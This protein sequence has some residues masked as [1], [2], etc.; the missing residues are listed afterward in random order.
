MT[1]AGRDSIA[2]RQLEVAGPMRKTP[3]ITAH[4][5]S[6]GF[7]STSAISLLL[8]AALGACASLLQP[9]WGGAR[10]SSAGL[11]PK[12]SI[13]PTASA[14]IVVVTPEP[15]ATL[16]PTPTE[17]PTATAVSE[18]QRV[19][20]LSLDGLRPEALS[21]SRTPVILALAASGASTLQARTVSPSVTLPA[22]ASMLSGYDVEDHGLTWNNYLPDRGFI[23]TPT[24]FSVA[25]ES[26]LGTEM[27][28]SSEKLV[29]IASPG[30]VDEFTYSGGG[31]SALADRAAPAIADGF[32]VL[33]LHLPGP[34]D[35]GHSSGWMSPVYLA[36]VANTDKAV[37]RILDALDAAGLREG[38]LIFLTTDHGG[39]DQSHGSSSPEDM[40]IPWIVAGP[41]VVP[42]S[43][44]SRRVVV[45]DTAATAMWAL[46]LDLPSDL[47]GRPVLE[48]FGEGP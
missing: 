43:K 4:R 28:V 15:T 14:T 46:G 11:P 30:T 6:A 45:Y 23:L 25:H 42:G 21:E 40:T 13:T 41:G 24:I 22:H 9:R 48:A 16:T 39:H 19:L 8:A 2:R 7:R 1:P 27:V 20:I 18:P 44:L 32:D 10:A 38:T 34:D 5:I 47:D 12:A 37:G 26:G 35:T 31:D 33:F 3:G 29:H 36:T 17:A